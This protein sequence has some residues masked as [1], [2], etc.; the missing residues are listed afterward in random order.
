VT[1][2]W[3]LGGLLLAACADGGGPDAGDA[4]LPTTY[5][6]QKV[7]FITSMAGE[8]KLITWLA[9]CSG[10]STGLEAA[11]CICQEHA[12]RWGN[13]SGTYRAWLSD[14]SHS[15]AAR[16]AHSSEPYVNRRGEVVAADWASLATLQCTDVLGYDEAGE[17]TSGLLWTGSQPSGDAGTE[18]E[19]CREW[20]S[21]GAGATGLAGS[22]TVDAYRANFPGCWSAWGLRACDDQNRLACFEQ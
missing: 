21:S 7:I 9:A 5:P 14:S 6:G 11:D 10:R 18:Y 22:A 16:L 3:L 8:G 4:G 1:R 12:K 13:L 20:N 19:T 17:P 15:A 2:G